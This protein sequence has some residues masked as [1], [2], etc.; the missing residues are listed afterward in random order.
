MSGKSYYLVEV[1]AVLALVEASAQQRPH[2]FLFDELFR[3]TNTVE[4]V[5][6]AHAVLAAL[7]EAR[8]GPR[9]HV[10]L[11]ATHDGELLDMLQDTYEPFHFSDR[12][13]ACG[14]VF[15]FVLKAGPST[16]RNAIALLSQCGAPESIVASALATVAAIDAQRSSNTITLPDSRQ[17]CI[18]QRR[19]S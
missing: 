15:D 7:I 3:G 8:E 14:L 16:T 6:A 17:V 18:E 10:V 4:R 1:E 13:D 12:I 2:L 19:Q 5:S 11:A 9:S